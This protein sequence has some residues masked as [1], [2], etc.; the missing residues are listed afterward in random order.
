MRLNSPGDAL[1][2]CRN[3]DRKNL[4][5]GAGTLATPYINNT[6]NDEVLRRNP[7][8]N[9]LQQNGCGIYNENKSC[10]TVGT[11][12]STDENVLCL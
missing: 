2:Q 8:S 7:Q 11:K 3:S 1:E 5:P 9:T 12:R 10:P 6:Q 4:G